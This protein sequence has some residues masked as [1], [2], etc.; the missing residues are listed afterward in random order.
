MIKISIILS[1]VLAVLVSLIVL[2]QA[3]NRE[4][5]S[6]AQFRA[7]SGYLEAKL[8]DGVTAYQVS[9]PENGP[10]LIILHGG[11]L[12]SLAYQGYV[13]PLAKAGYRVV[14]YDQYGRGFSDRPKAPLSIDLMRHQLRELMDHLQIKQANLFGVSFGGA[15]LARFG[16]MHPERVLALA[17]QVPVIEGASVGLTGQLVA[18]PIVGP[19]LSRF[20]AIPSIISRGESFGTET[21]EARRV[22]A[23]FTE[24]FNVQGTERMMR[25]LLLGDALSNRMADHVAIGARGVRA[26]FVYATDDPEIK[27]EQVEAALAHY[28]SPDVHKYKGGHFFSSGKTDELAAKLDGFFQ[29]R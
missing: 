7:D 17:Y 4:T 24:Q 14:V 18:L 10:A 21:E 1:V 25:D 9:C 27:A 16:A 8:S 15:I 28:A 11:T 3:G 20:V 22:V 12:G 29:P 26:Q 6:A 23:H 19:L 2:Y 13:P 5:Q